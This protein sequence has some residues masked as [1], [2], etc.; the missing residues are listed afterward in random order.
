MPEPKRIYIIEDG[1]KPDPVALAASDL[2]V[3]LT[4]GQVDRGPTAVWKG[5]TIKDREDLLGPIEIVRN[6]R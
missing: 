5:E 6:L 2:V 3:K 1:Q 4:G